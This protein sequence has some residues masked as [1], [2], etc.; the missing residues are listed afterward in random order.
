MNQGKYF[1][2]TLTNVLIKHNNHVVS[3]HIRNVRVILNKI[4]VYMFYYYHWADT[5]GG[6]LSVL[7][8]RG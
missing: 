7:S 4:F 8:P 5:F 2:S 3:A 1:Q 6:G